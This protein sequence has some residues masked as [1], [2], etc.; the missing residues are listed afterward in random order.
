M[1]KLTIASEMQT[2]YL[3][4]SVVLSPIPSTEEKL[5]C[6]QCTSMKF[7]FPY[8]LMGPASSTYQESKGENKK[9]TKENIL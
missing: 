4:L 1:L 9:G 3:N 6:L 2:I 8:K 5:P 7:P